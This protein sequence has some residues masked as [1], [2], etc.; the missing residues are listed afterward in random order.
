VRDS[1]K[2]LRMVTARANA[3]PG[4]GIYA[5]VGRGDEFLEGPGR[6]VRILDMDVE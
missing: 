5:D 2:T 3:S 6:C 1:G 4:F